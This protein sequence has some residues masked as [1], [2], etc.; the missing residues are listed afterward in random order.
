MD[1]SIIKR[2]LR[3]LMSHSE[4]LESCIDN[5]HQIETLYLLDELEKTIAQSIK[6]KSA[7]NSPKFHPDTI[8][9][10]KIRYE[11]S[12]IEYAPALNDQAVI[13]AIIALQ[14]KKRIKQHKTSAPVPEKVTTPEI[15]S[16]ISEIPAEPVEPTIEFSPTIIPYLEDVIPKSSPVYKKPTSVSTIL[17]SQIR[18]KNA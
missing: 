15:Q 2:M 6:T 9:S 18:S 17:R 4:T 1:S 7:T 10:P 12:H 14:E 5:N 13:A 11:T 8:S 16:D 3:S